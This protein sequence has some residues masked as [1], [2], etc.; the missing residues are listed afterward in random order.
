MDRWCDRSSPEFNLHFTLKKSSYGIVS[1]DV[2]YKPFGD[3]LVVSFLLMILIRIVPSRFTKAL[4]R[5]LFIVS[6]AVS[7]VLTLGSSDR[8]ARAEPEEIVL[9]IPAY[10]QISYSTYDDLVAQ[11][12]SLV[13]SVIVRQ[14]SQSPDLSA[15]KVV[16]LGS[17]N[18]D[19]VPILSTTVSRTQW[20]KK[21][22]V[23]A[24]TQYYPAYA[25]LQRR[26]RVQ[27]E[28]TAA[29]PARTAVAISQNRAAAIDRAFD[30]GSLTGAVA[31]EYLSNLD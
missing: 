9:E 7:V 8:P 29:S 19:R 17:R 30:D 13:R 5:R 22:Q 26:D 1:S 14:F 24:W 21:P 20:Q 31:Q 10:G 4:I 12:E 15:I 16:V 28:T 23:S 27:P 2:T 25:L 3:I 18:S 11:A 6:T